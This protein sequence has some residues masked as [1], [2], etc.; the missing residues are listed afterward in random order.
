MESREVKKQ[1]EGPGCLKILDPA[2]GRLDRRFCSDV[3]RSAYHNKKRQRFD[4]EVIRINRIL[5][6]NF[7]ILQKSLGERR[8][9][10]I[11][12]ET[13]LRRGFSFDYYTQVNGEY[14]FCYTYG[15]TSRKENYILIVKGFD[16]IVK[17]E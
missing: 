5:E 2:H 3:C 6:Q 7:E 13:L 12:R 11:A 14:K 16:T 9:V 4:P 8:S 1:C 17:K 10:S 15:Y